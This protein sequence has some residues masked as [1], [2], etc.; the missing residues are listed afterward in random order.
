MKHLILIVIVTALTNPAYGLHIRNSDDTSYTITLSG[1]GFTEVRTVRSGGIV[2]MRSP[3]LVIQLNDGP[4]IQTRIN[5]EYIIQNGILRL[6]R[7]N[8]RQNS[9]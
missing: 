7:H 1:A 8:Y 9:H 6:M 5:Q 4:L 3:G 2:S